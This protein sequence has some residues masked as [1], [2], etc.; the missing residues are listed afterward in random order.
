MV[1][2]YNKEDLAEVAQV[3]VA[4]L[5]HGV[6]VL[7]DFRHFEGAFSSKISQTSR[8]PQQK[9]LCRWFKYTTRKTWPKCSKLRL[10]S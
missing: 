2:K 10:Q 9:P 5:T 8:R 4:I 6:D 1:Q 7:S 3:E